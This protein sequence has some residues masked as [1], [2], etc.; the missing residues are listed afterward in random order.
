VKATNGAPHKL[1]CKWCVESDHMVSWSPDGCTAFLFLFVSFLS[2]D[3]L[4]LSLSNSQ[5]ILSCGVLVC[6]IP[7]VR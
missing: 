2:D 6:F 4:L 1:F 3:E 7:F 5:R